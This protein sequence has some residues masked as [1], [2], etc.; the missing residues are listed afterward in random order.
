MDACSCSLGLGLGTL[1]LGLK[2]EKRS[3]NQEQPNLLR[4]FETPPS[5]TIPLRHL[6]IL[7]GEYVKTNHVNSL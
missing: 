3:F 7:S 5:R 4:K 1:G 2:E 6:H